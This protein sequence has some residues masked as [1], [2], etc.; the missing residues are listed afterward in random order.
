MSTVTR[1]VTHNAEVAVNA[2]VSTSVPPGA[3]V[4]GGSMSSPVPVSTAT[5]KAVTMIRADRAGVSSCRCSGSRRR[6]L[7]GT[8]RGILDPCVRAR[9][10]AWRRASVMGTGSK[11]TRRGGTG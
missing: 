8:A 10:A 4:A 3:V 5:R 7:R 2:A 9:I 11:Y 6:R 1:P